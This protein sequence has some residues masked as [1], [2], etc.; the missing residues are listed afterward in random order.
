MI[1]QKQS[2]GEHQPVSYI[3]RTLTPAEQCYAQIEKEALAVTWACER[4]SHYLTG[5]QFH[6]CTDHKPLVPLLGRK[7]L[8]ELPLRVQRFRMRLMR[9]QY[10]I[11]H[12]PG[13]SLI[14]ADALSRTPTDSPTTEDDKL[15]QETD[16]YVDVVMSN[17]PATD[18]RLTE[19]K[20]VQ[21]KDSTCVM[22]KKYCKE[23]W[24]TKVAEEQKQ[25]KLV[26][27]EL[28]VHK[29]R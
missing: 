9:F 28:S 26:A 1:T 25:Y 8:D 4:L 10:T 15:F 21:D 19:I 23:G 3:S 13:K 16:A 12:I 17:L 27:S 11:S 24:P 20:E 22:V 14:T 2:K 18:K 6:I 5:M 7:N 29:G